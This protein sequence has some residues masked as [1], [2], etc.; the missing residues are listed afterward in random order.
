MPDI[1][2]ILETEMSILDAGEPAGWFWE[3]DKTAVIMGTSGKEEVEAERST[4]REDG[5]EI[6]KRRSGG[7]TIV[8]GKGVLCF[9]VVLEKTWSKVFPSALAE[10]VLTPVCKALSVGG[11]EITIKG[12]GDLSFKDKKICGTAQRWIKNSVLFH[13]S[14]LVD[15][16]ITLIEKYLKHPPKEP[17]YREGRGHGDFCVN[18]AEVYEEKTSVKDVAALIQKSLESELEVEVRWLS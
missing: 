9:G 3:A 10:K 7:G 2:E 6:L 5:I 8:V 11:T 16:D 1:K 17:D 14:I 18:L 15:F 13:G 4:C 12:L